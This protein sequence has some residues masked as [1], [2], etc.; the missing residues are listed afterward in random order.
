MYLVDKILLAE[1]K[2]NKDTVLNNNSLSDEQKVIL[3]NEFF[4]KHRFQKNKD[5][6]MSLAGY[7]KPK[8]V[9]VEILVHLWPSI[10][11]LP[12]PIQ[13][14]AYALIQKSKNFRI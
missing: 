3:Y 1:K 2:N 12:T 6:D 4:K 7:T 10:E 9:K 5:L 14:Q 8:K 11:N 13:D